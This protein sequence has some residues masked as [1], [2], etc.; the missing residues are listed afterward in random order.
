MIF[1]ILSFYTAAVLLRKW[2]QSAEQIYVVITIKLLRW[3][4]KTDFRKKRSEELWYF[5]NQ[6]ETNRC[7]RKEIFMETEFL[8]NQID[9]G[10]C[11]LLLL[12]LINFFYKAM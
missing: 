3:T 8:C 12:Q 10:K 6:V 5:H 1:H 7:K 2:C 11:K 9:E 4:Y